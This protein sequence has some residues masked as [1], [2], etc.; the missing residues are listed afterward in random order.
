MKKVFNW[1]KRNDCFWWILIISI[2]LA[3][4]IGTVFFWDWMWK[5]I[6]IW[7]IIYLIFSFFGD[8]SDEWKKY[9]GLK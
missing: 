1:L 5:H 9:H 4:I 7:I 3:V 8:G 6:Y 2:I